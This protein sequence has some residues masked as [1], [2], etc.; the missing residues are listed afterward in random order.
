MNTQIALER[1]SSLPPEA[2]QQVIDFIDFLKTRY[3]STPPQ[4]K[5]QTQTAL[6]QETFIG[7]WQER[8]E[9]QDSTEWVRKLRRKE[10]G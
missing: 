3:Q 2:Q 9:M 6:A 4:K 1:L 7:I 5:K 10:W 8:Q